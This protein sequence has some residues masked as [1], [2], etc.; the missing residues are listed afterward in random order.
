MGVAL[1]TRRTL[2]CCIRANELQLEKVVE[3]FMRGL[4]SF[5]VGAA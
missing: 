2:Q 4:P 3:Y 1:V 5:R